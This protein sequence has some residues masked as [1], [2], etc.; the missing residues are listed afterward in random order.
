METCDIIVGAAMEDISVAE[1]VAEPS[2]KP[3]PTATSPAAAIPIS[4]RILKAHPP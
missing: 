3:K 4:A 2:Q 1:W